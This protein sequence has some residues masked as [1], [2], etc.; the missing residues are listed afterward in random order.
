MKR[1]A[2]RTGGFTLIELMVT[3]A[4]AA[5]LM[6]IAAPSFVSFQRNSELTG[7]ANSLLA[8][9][10]AAR[11]EGMKRNMT[12]MVVPA[13]GSTWE[14][15]WIV[16]IDVDRSETYSPGDIVVSRQGP[17][18]SYFSANGDGSAKEGGG[19]VNIRFSGSGYA[20]KADGTAGN[21]T[22]S[23]TRN[24]L[25]GQPQLDQT[26]RVIVANTGRA[27]VC[28]PMSATDANCLATANS[29]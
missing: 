28:K 17:L 23:L 9:I 11:S 12:A 5:I 4:I 21:L 19:A 25:S 13:D 7:A 3:V 6:M 16:F 18:A 15:G 8:S 10:N 24:D 20:T 2:L 1:P 14:S 26:R 27:R 22:W 29:F